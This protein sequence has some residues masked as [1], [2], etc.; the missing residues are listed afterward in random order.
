MEWDG[1][2]NVG[3]DQLE[4]LW[5]GEPGAGGGQR[6]RVGL[7][8]KEGALPCKPG[9]RGMS[10]TAEGQIQTGQFKNM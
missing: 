10:A 3:R 9:R 8:I 4:M 6:G 2:I 1:A 7:S 5:E